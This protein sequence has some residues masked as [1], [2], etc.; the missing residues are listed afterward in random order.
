MSIFREIDGGG[1]AA[2]EEEEEE[3]EDDEE[4]EEEEDEDDDEAKETGDR[5]VATEGPIP[6][7]ADLSSADRRDCPITNPCGRALSS[8]VPTVGS[9]SRR[10]GVPCV[11]L[12]LGARLGEGDGEKDPEE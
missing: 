8:L 5:E 12:D 6:A 9:Q 11:W 3:E 2:E 4:N 1:G 10:G 7:R